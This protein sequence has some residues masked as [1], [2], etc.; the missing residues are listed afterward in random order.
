M[1]NSIFDLNISFHISWNFEESL[2]DSIE[3][4]H[5][6]LV[7]GAKLVDGALVLD[8]SSYVKTYPIKGSLIEKTFEVWLLLYDIRTTNGGIIS[9][10]SGGLFDAIVW[11]EG[12]AHAGMWLAGSNYFTHTKVF[13]GLE[14]LVQSL[15]CTLLWSIAMMVLL[16]ATEM[17]CFMGL[18]IQLKVCLLLHIQLS[19]SSVALVLAMD[20]AMQESTMLI[21]TMSLWSQT[22]F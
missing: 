16:L 18:L 22:K 19:S 21:Y 20:I 15:M 17:V 7:G 4:Q 1:R 6:S 13:G 11:S 9:L 5:G 8:G 14:L 12:F 2:E 3:G 10:N